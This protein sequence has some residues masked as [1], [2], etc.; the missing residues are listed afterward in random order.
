MLAL[1]HQEMEGPAVGEYQRGR[2]EG[3]TGKG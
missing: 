3:E 1:I 2:G